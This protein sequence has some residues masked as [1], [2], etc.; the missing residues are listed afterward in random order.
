MMLDRSATSS[1]AEAS[2]RNTSSWPSAPRLLRHLLDPRFV[3]FGTTLLLLG[4]TLASVVLW[5]RNIGL[6][7]DWGMVAA[8]TGN[9]P[10]LGAW[11]WSQ[12]NEHRLPVQRLLYLGL[13]KLTGDFRSGMVFS[14]LLL[15]LLALACAWAARRVRG[16]Q[17]WTDMVFPLA[18]L[19]LGHWENLVWGWQIQF[20]YSV[21]LSGLLLVLVASQNTLGPRV[22]LA[23]ALLLLLLPLSGANGIVMG[24]AL[25]PWLA[26]HGAVRMGLARVGPLSLGP[27]TPVSWTDRLTGAAFLAGAALTF[28]AIGN[29]FIGYV[30]P[31]WSPP[32]ASPAQFAAAAE[33]YFAYALGPGARHLSLLAAVAVAGFIVCGG[34][35]ALRATVVGSPN[36]RLRAAGLALFIGAG[37]ALGLAIAYARGSYEGRL[38]DRYAL[39]AVLPL[40][41]AVFAWELYAPRRI[42][43]VAVAGLLVGFVL[44]LPL[45]IRAGFEWRNWYVAGMSAL[46]ADM[47]ANVPIPQLAARHHP[48]LMH[49][50]ED[51]LRDAM[52]MLHD[53]GIGPFGATSH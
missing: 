42:A 20:V 16:K 14:Q 51:R 48:F 15:A 28:G 24:A 2:N 27:V 7:E 45:N 22:G 10:D 36:E 17:R 6:A 38:P 29:Y 44:L 41:G 1:E 32:P 25:A 21:L 53:A 30:S 43:R 31:P 50:S 39:F 37:A 5:G 8:M 11:A 4:T 3:V 9:E 23:A 40:L 13:L 12:N 34:L 19:H 35:I 47:A 49:W 18:L 46:E 52:Q 26:A 33:S